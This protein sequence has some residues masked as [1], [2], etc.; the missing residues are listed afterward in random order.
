MYIIRKNNLSL[1][2]S[3]LFSSVQIS[4][5]N[6]LQFDDEGIEKS[7]RGAKDY[8]SIPGPTAFNLMRSFLPGGQFHSMQFTEIH[9][10]LTRKYGPIYKLCGSFGRNDI[11]VVTDPKDFEV[12]FRTEGSFPV[13]RGLDTLAY[14]R[15][16]IRKD[17]FPTSIGLVNEQGQ[18]WWNLRHKVNDVMMKPQITKGYTTAVDEVSKDF[19]KKLHNMRDENLETPPDLFYQLNIWALESIANVMLNTRLGL[20]NEKPNENLGLLMENVKDFFQLMFEL[21]IQPSVWKYYKT[22]K[23]NRFVQIMDELHGMIGNYVEKGIKNLQE[24][25]T[26][27]QGNSREKGVLEKLY[28]IDK[29]V[30]ILMA[31]DALLAGVDTSSSGSFSIL[32]N[33]AKNPEKQNILR[34]ELLKILPEKD[35]PLT[36]ENMREMPYLRACI[37]EAFRMMPVVSG[38]F[39]GTGRDIVLRGYQIPRDTDVY[40]PNKAVHMNDH[41][42]PEAESFI[43]ER[44]LRSQEKHENYNPFT[45]LPFGY[46]IRACIGRRFAELEMEALVSRLVRNY[47]LEWH[48]PPPGIQSMTINIPMGD[49]KLRLKEYHEEWRT[50]KPYSRIP[51]PSIFFLL[52]NYMPDGE[53]SNLDFL[54][55]HK[56]LRRNFGPIYKLKGI[57]GK[58]DMVVVDDPKDF[59][60]LF[61]AE[62]PF[63]I[64]RGMDAITYYRKEYRKDHYS[65][66]G[67]IMC[68][69]GE[70][71][72][73]LRQKLN[74][75]IMKP[76][77]INEYTS[78]IDEISSEFAARWGLLEEKPNEQIRKLLEYFQILIKLLFELDFQPSLYKIFKTFKFKY[79]LQTYEMIENTLALLY[80]LAKN[81]EKQEILRKELLKVLP[82]KDSLLT[83][84]NMKNLPYLRACI[85]ESVRMMPVL[86]GQMRAPIRNI[87]LSGY[88]IP[89]N[90]DV[91]MPNETLYRK[92]CYFTE[93]NSFIPERWLRESEKCV[94][95]NPYVYL[96][97]GYGRR[98]CVGRRI[99]QLEMET[100]TSRLIRNFYLEWHHPPPKIR[101]TTVNIPYG[102]LNWKAAKPYESIPG[103]TTYELIR[104]FL[105]G[106][107]Y[108]GVSMSEVHKKM[109]NLYGPIY[110]LKGTFGKGDIV[111]VFDPKD[112]EVVY[113]TE[114]TFPIRRGLDSLTYY[115]K[116][117]RKDKYPISHGLVIE[118]GQGWWDLRQKVNGVMMK[119]QV[120]KGYTSAVDEVSSDFVKKLHT[121]RDTNLETPPNFL[122]HLNLWTLESIAY[123]TMNMRLGLLG[124]KP[125]ESVEKLMFDLK[126]FFQLLFELDFRPSIWKFYKTPKF[127]RFMEIMDYM[128]EVIGKFVD[129]GLENLKENAAK[130]NST[131]RDKSVLEKLYEIDKNIAV[132]MSLDSLTSSATFMVL[133]NLA[134]N[135][136]KQNI[137][138]EELLKILPD[139]DSPLTVDNMRNMPYL[140]ASIKEALRVTPVTVGNIRSTGKDI[141]LKGYQI[142]KHTD[143]FMNSS[144][145]YTDEHYFPEAESFIPE[146]WLRSQEKHE[147]YN[148]FT[149]LPFG[150]GHRNCIG[151]RFAEM[152]IESLTSR[153]WVLEAHQLLKS[154][155]VD[156]MFLVRKRYFSANQLR[157]FTAQAKRGQ[158]WWDLRHKVNGVM[159][160]PQVTKGYTSAVDEVSSDFATATEF[161]DE[162]IQESWKAAKPYESIPGPTTYG[163]I[164]GFLA[165]GQYSGVPMSEVH[166]SMRNHYGPIYRLKGTFGKRDIV[167]VFDPKD[168]EVVYRTE[169]TFPIRRGLDSLTYYRKEY[170]KDKYPISLGLVS[171]Q[172]QGW[173]DLRHKVNGVMMKPQVTKGYTS[174]VDEVSSDFVKKLHTLRDA[175][176]ETPANFLL[177]L[178]LWALES[179]AYITMNMRLGLLGEKPDESVD[180]LMVVLKEFFQLMFELDFQ[181]S[182]WKFYKTPKFNRFMEIMDYMHELHTL[183]DANLE[184]PANFLL[185]LNLWALESIAYITMNM[186]LGL[187]GEKPDESVDKLMAVLKEFFQLMYEL[188]FQPS[189]WKFYKTPKFNRFMEIMDYMHE[190]IGKFVDKGLENLKE[191]AA[192]GENAGR[193]KGVLE[194]LYEIDKD[195]AVLMALDSLLAGVDTTAG[196]T[197][198]TLYNLAKN[199]EKQ[200]ILREELLKIL[201][202]KDSPLTTENMKNMPYLRACIKEAIRLMPVIPGNLRTTG[203]DIVL[204]GYQIPKNTDI[205]MFNQ[206]LHLDEGY[207]PD[208]KAFIPERWLRSQEKHENYNPFTYL[209]F[210]F[211]SRNCVGRRFAEMEIETLVS[212]LVRN[213]V[214]E[215]HHP[216][217]TIRSIAINMATGDLK[218]R[219]RD[220]Q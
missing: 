169:G 189:I 202:E 120:T 39:R 194:K 50:A 106:G 79:F 55:A 190:V 3:R 138:R 115:R 44:W 15:R 93:P 187:L 219:L 41:Y 7:W 69:Q 214:L 143:V 167:A 48:Y 160:K 27:Q 34:E 83:E 137:L 208:A 30:A 145:I 182:I 13:R 68:E 11:A 176:L 1:I 152:E 71:W 195:V 75:V 12:V 22:A 132:L 206:F 20:L 17:T 116:V 77:V 62:G 213:Y 180:K 29:D 47:H 110:R 109:R 117:Y 84:E 175:N 103:P 40:M 155:R 89:K 56:I 204:K 92:E 35:S 149:Y 94:K 95:I 76:D 90:T 9:Q 217:P 174:A 91:F 49:L 157:C 168:F 135:P 87:V 215:W 191:N 24:T 100:L 150:F 16:Y 19:V 86:S 203:Q 101:S 111:L 52:R 188:D 164:R 124:E 146:R 140:R 21:D 127:N 172:G 67:G 33:L 88:Q 6:I 163:L 220:Y 23:F 161:D 122:L 212:R 81:P 114:G 60:A 173:W 102:D 125:D 97:F 43:P 74:G 197:F 210:G 153:L 37:K 170:R 78:G 61:Q 144:M 105:A 66:T 141:I 128:H 80:Y 151:R 209:P 25:N 126:E 205:I 57:F 2:K 38:N 136:E 184:T 158:G 196:A 118:Q 178:N 156:K 32:Y 198:S 18:R 46:G 107:Q 216:P 165:G 129:K 154:L 64:R 148:P 96:P 181:P 130:G 121:L 142:P 85:K 113:R 4:K 207:F 5:A 26:N 59:E 58:R 36:A 179:I 51:G 112:F 139:K 63:P 72:W 119:P 171:E 193:E 134:K 14:Y 31:L 82:K 186:R 45:Y 53:L 108:S 218:L 162:A 65:L 200:N 147:N 99:A 8:E 201:P 98:I 211:G 70:A 185:H 199:P 73:D 192:K 10:V 183:R 133:Y 177:H 166:K 159:M 131:D 123:I 104:G 54:E 42:F 28:E